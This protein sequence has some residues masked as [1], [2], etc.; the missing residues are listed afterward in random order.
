M[1]TKN[2]WIQFNK[3][4][5][6]NLSLL[7]TR[8]KKLKELVAQIK[9]KA[10]EKLITV[11]GGISAHL[12][13]QPQVMNETLTLEF[14]ISLLLVE[15][16]LD[17][18]SKLSSEFTRQVEVASMRLRSAVQGKQTPTLLWPVGP[19]LKYRRGGLME[20]IS[21]ECGAG[22]KQIEEVLDS[23]FRDSSKSYELPMLFPLFK[24]ISGVLVILEFERTNAFLVACRN[25]I[26]KFSR[27]DY[28]YKHSEHVRLA[29][30]LSSIGFFIEGLKYDQ[31]D[32][33]NIIETAI[34]QFG[35]DIVAAA[36]PTVSN[37]LAESTPIVSSDISS[38]ELAE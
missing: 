5:K 30:G 37:E 4:K 24:Q 36:V 18:F 15:S 8:I 38:D 13:V 31:H 16:A 12:K 33:A 19:A 21:H 25:L 11:I 35:S 34:S 10:L 32:R 2:A 1:K 17:N 9:H 23:F 22:L 6:N 27:S 14:A 29:E 3:G 26:E 7:L 28:E 20:Q